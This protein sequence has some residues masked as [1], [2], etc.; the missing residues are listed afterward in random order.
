VKAKFFVLG[1]ILL[2]ILSLAASVYAQT[3]QTY[4]KEDFNYASINQMQ[5]AGWTFTRPAGISL[6]S[7]AL[8]LDGTAGD[9]A[10]HYT[11]SFSNPVYDWKAEVKT[12]WMGQGHS[13]LSVFV[14]TEKHS[15]GWAAD[16]YYKEFSLYRDSQRILH[17]GNYQ[18]TSNQFITLTMVRQGNTFSFYFNGNLINTYTEEDTAPSKITSLG[19]VSPWKGDAKYDYIMIGEPTALSPTMPPTVVGSDFPTVPVVIGGTVTAV[20]VG[21]ILVYYFVIAGGSTGASAGSA[22]GGAGG[23]TGG[24]SV[25]QEQQISPLSG[26]KPPELYGSN[27]AT[28]SSLQNAYG[29]N[30][31]SYDQYLQEQSQ[32]YQSNSESNYATDSSL[33]NAYGQNDQSY[34]QYLQEQSQYYQSNQQSQ[35]SPSNETRAQQQT[36]QTN[37]TSNQ[38][39]TADQ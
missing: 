19:L 37:T 11:T 2:F 16:G 13:V 24:G 32:Y 29:Q 27:Y 1:A 36:K 26:E 17:F 10:A 31:Q 8:V 39:S 28:D 22:A 12:M 38:D 30:D 35:Q 6:S 15:Y 20:V 14:N 3:G 4:F 25:I 33:Q 9:C 23:A 18:E 34:D 5:S 21:G 7:N